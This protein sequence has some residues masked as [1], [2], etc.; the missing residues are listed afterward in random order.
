M[1]PSLAPTVFV[2]LGASQFDASTRFGHNPAFKGTADA[3]RAYAT[4]SPNG[5]GIPDSQQLRLFDAPISPSEQCVR[6]SDFLKQHAA[7]RSVIV[8]YVGHGTFTSDNRYCLTLRGTADGFESSSALGTAALAEALK[9]F[10]DRASFLILDCCFA[11]E[12]VAP[13]MGGETD[14]VR[15]QVEAT[16]PTGVAM[17]LASSK[18]DVASAPPSE[19]MTRFGQVLLEVLDNGLEHRDSRLS[20][21]EVGHAMRAR[22]AMRWG[23]DN[24]APEVQSPRQKEGDLA[25]APF[26]PNPAREPAPAAAGRSAAPQESRPPARHR[27]IAHRPAA[28]LLPLAIGALLA[29]AGAAHA[30]MLA[31][32]LVADTAFA[33]GMTSVAWGTLRLTGAPAWLPGRSRAEALLALALGMLVY[34]LARGA[35]SG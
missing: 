16:F 9:P 32:T 8:A 3:L 28:G 21:R 10:G 29:A 34:G 31:R 13:F 25:D 35:V 12:A 1:S 14:L 33:V 18:H 30:L 2:L 5:L 23:N 20:L 22:V 7:A 6:I 24:A 15:T 19:P 26:F 17:L 4:R 11:G 27:A